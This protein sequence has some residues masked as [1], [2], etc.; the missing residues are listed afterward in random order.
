LRE[1]LA[2]TQEEPIPEDELARA[3]RKIASQL[4]IGAE[5]PM[6][7]LTAVGFD[8][9][10]R[11]KIE[12]LDELVERYGSVSGESVAA[13]LGTRPFDALTLV[14]LGPEPAGVQMAP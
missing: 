10:Y 14:A 11:G 2:G 7:R 5:T 3:R 6:G 9:V 8:W 12:R 4:V 13:L 1:T